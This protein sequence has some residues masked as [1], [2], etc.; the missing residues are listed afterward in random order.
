MASRT[1]HVTLT[2]KVE[3][4]SDQ[5]CDWTVERERE[6]WHLTALVLDADYVV[7]A[8]DYPENGVWDV[9]A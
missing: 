7:S 1:V 5:M 9:N 4:P 2:Y 8:V 3:G 6:R